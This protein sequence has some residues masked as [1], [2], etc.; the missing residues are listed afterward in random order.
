MYAKAVIEK[1]S[2]EVDQCMCNCMPFGIPAAGAE[3]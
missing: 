1:L 3:A 2:T